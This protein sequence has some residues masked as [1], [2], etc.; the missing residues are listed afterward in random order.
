MKKKFN[1]ISCPCSSYAVNNSNGTIGCERN[2]FGQLEYLSSV[3]LN[4]HL[5]N[6]LEPILGD[7]WSC[8]NNIKCGSPGFDWNTLYIVDVVED[9]NQANSSVVQT[10]SSTSNCF[11]PKSNFKDYET[12]EELGEWESFQDLYKIT[13][14]NTDIIKTT[15]GAPMFDNHEAALVYSAGIVKGLH[16]NE[17][18][19]YYDDGI[20][21][22]VPGKY[23]GDQGLITGIAVNGVDVFQRII[24]QDFAYE[25]TSSSKSKITIPSTG[26]NLNISIQSEGAASA[27][28]RL[29]DSAGCSVFKR[30]K[31]NQ[32][33]KSNHVINEI[34]PALG[35]GKTQE[36]YDVEITPSAGVQYYANS[37]YGDFEV[38]TGVF[39][40]KVFQFQ[41]PT[42]TLSAKTCLLANTN[43]TT[44]SVSVKGSSNTNKL[45][46]MGLTPVTH[47]TTI[48]ASGDNIYY[49]SKKQLLLSDLI[50][51][52]SVIKKT[53]IN[54][55]K[56]VECMQEI[57]VAGF[58]TE[59]IGDLEAEMGFYGK[60]E[61]TKILKKS[62]DLETNKEPCDDCGEDQ[63]ILTNKFEFEN[64]SD[65]F[66]GM[67][68]ICTSP[69]GTD[70][71]TQ[72]KSIDCMFGITLA[73]HYVIN[74]GTTVTFKYEYNGHVLEVNGNTLMLDG[75][76]SFPNNTP[77]TFSKS[78][79]SVIEG[80]V[81]VDK[82][83]S[84]EVIITTVI[85]GVKFGQGD[86]AFELDP[87]LFLSLVPNAYDQNI[88]VAK[89]QIIGVD[90]LRSDSDFNN[91]DKR[92]TTVTG[93]KKGTLGQI[94]KRYTSYTPNKGFT[95]EDK[96]VF[97]SYVPETSSVAAVFSEEKIV[98]IKIK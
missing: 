90:F 86:V 32:V 92:V 70:I 12:G 36:V 22:F 42:L 37:G 60:V 66:V 68:F 5:I 26:G 9:N 54:S 19:Q 56:I 11:I 91:K 64:T 4:N 61:K 10:T 31:N 84:A 71:V 81:A 78:N 6:N 77:L 65:L 44:T 82:S 16:K 50:T 76:V 45:I 52:S 18:S 87:N 46:A 95:G 40:C 93:P 49:K 13:G 1:T 94:N 30:K 41:D 28:I 14:F 53:I 83:G 2:N 47:T 39:K 59:G 23:Y 88:V 80:T 15:N 3:V 62:I 89:D 48:T 51:D 21:R 8:G 96:I 69:E 17:V 35:L 72:I 55:P 38:G 58:G 67:R 85:D 20:L 57:Q 98:T 75:C 79:N 63:D 27:S 7:K 25:T 29:T 33:L 24:T 43:T 74:T 97:K 73:D 34:I